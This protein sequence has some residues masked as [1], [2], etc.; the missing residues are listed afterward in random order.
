MNW[1]K[2]FGVFTVFSIHSKKLI[3]VDLRNKFPKE[4][5]FKGFQLNIKSKNC[6]QKITPFPI[7]DVEKSFTYKM[8]SIKNNQ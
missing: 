5:E 8:L 2:F 1:G 4:I 6:T 7:Y 3:P